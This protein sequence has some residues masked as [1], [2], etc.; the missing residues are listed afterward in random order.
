MAGRVFFSANEMAELGEPAIPHEAVVWR[1]GRWF[2]MVGSMWEVVPGSSWSWTRAMSTMRGKE[3]QEQSSEN[4]YWS[5]EIVSKARAGGAAPGSNPA[6]PKG[7]REVGRHSRGCCWGEQLRSCEG[8]GNTCQ[9]Q[10]NGLAG[11]K[12]RFQWGEG[13]IG[14]STSSLHTLRSPPLWGRQG[15]L[16]QWVWDQPKLRET[17]TTQGFS[18]AFQGPITPHSSRHLTSHVVLRKRSTPLEP[19]PWPTLLR[20]C[21]ACWFPSE[22]SPNKR[23]CDIKV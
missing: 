3:N 21:L 12:A 18:H 11:A 15:T 10:T 20:L 4:P 8:V 17:T 1:R 5:G 7:V 23:I 14:I 2:S 19:S 13:K 6:L 22:S 16:P 9:R